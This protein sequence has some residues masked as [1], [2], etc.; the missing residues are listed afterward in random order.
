[1]AGSGGNVLP[2]V[3]IWFGENEI[4][5]IAILRNDVQGEHIS[6]SKMFQIF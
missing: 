4:P 1:L 5:G 3:F 6:T 2:E